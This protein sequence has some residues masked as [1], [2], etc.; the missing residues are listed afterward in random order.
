MQISTLTSLNLSGCRRITDEGLKE[1]HHADI[2][3]Q[4]FYNFYRTTIVTFKTLLTAIVVHGFGT[5]L[6]SLPQPH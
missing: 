4:T 6:P 5:S 3:P 2:R 1:Q